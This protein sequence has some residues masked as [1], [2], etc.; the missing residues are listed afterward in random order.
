M[1]GGENYKIHGKFMGKFSVFDM[2]HLKVAVFV[3][4]HESNKQML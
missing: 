1:T 2:S 4:N 3:K